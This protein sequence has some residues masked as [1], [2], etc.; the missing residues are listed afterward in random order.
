MSHILLGDF[1]Y[2]LLQRDA[3]DLECLIFGVH[4]TVPRLTSVPGTG[5]V[6]IRPDGYVDLRW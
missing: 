6:A 4:V 3:K 1:L 2:V 5:L